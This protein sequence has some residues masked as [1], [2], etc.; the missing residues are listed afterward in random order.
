MSQ[1]EPLQTECY[2]LLKWSSSCGLSGLPSSLS[3]LHLDGNKITKMT[4]A[5]LKGLKNLAK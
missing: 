3:E 5:S 2:F 1:T 4:A